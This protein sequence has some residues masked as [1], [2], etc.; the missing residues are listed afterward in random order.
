MR[1]VRRVDAMVVKPIS[2]PSKKLSALEGAD[3]AGIAN[4]E[5]G[6]FSSNVTVFGLPSSAKKINTRMV[7]PAITAGALTPTLAGTDENM[8]G[9]TSTLGDRLLVGFEVDL[10]I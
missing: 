2:P 8:P 4:S 3:Q 9:V 1:T 7:N 10:A 6:S 5:S